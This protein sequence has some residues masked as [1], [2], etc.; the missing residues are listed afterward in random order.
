MRL[1]LVDLHLFLNVAEAASIT[2]GA[3]KTNLAL[4]E[5]S[6]SAAWRSSWA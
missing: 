5:A 1:D 2:H 3:A 6:A 4:A